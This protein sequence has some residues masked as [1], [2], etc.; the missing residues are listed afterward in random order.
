MEYNFNNNLGLKVESGFNKKAV[1]YL[2]S[3]Y[4]F[5]MT[6]FEVTPSLKFDFGKNIA[7]GFICLWG[8][9]FQ[10]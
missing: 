2:N 6:F 4:D 5:K 8:Q 3:N 10:R 1:S 7:K 9:N